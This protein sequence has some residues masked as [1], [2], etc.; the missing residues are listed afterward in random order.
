MDNKTLSLFQR[1]RREAELRSKELYFE[2]KK[3]KEICQIVGI[4]PVILKNLIYGQPGQEGWKVERERIEAKALK[5]I[6]ANQKQRY[7]NLID[8]T[9]EALERSVAHLNAPVTN[10]ETGEEERRILTV[11]EM[12]KVAKIAGTMQEMLRTAVDNEDDNVR[13]GQTKVRLTVE[14]LVH[15]LRN[16]DPIGFG[17]DEWGDD[18]GD[19]IEVDFDVIR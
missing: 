3:Q 12:E 5:Q 2:G 4:E 10:P 7:L 15:S 9:L 16:V 13:P 14:T 18:E 6:A 19:S 11:G 8:N 17:A 1:D